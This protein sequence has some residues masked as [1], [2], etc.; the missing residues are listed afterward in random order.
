MI[1]FF[2]GFAYYVCQ[3]ET[4]LASV[5]NYFNTSHY[6][7]PA[8]P[9][10]ILDIYCIP[11]F[12]LNDIEHQL[13]GK[14]LKSDVKGAIERIN[15]TK[16]YTSFDGYSPKNNK[17]RCY[18]YSVYEI[19]NQKGETAVYRPELFKGENLSFQLVCSLIGNPMISLFPINYEINNVNL[20]LIIENDKFNMDLGL[21]ISNLPR[22]RLVK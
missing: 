2:L 17:L 15:Y 16:N 21:N 8:R 5:L 12:A 10:A 19:T 20:P 13:E 3:D 18:P 7:I 6:D 14:L 4:E 22:C 9:E 11:D 1:I